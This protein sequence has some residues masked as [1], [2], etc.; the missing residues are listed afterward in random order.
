[1]RYKLD[2]GDFFL[3][4]QIWGLFLIASVWIAHK[5]DL[6]EPGAVTMYVSIP[7]ALVM[8]ALVYFRLNDLNWPRILLLPMPLFYAWVLAKE[9]ASTGYGPIPLPVVAILGIYSGLLWLVVCFPFKQE[10]AGGR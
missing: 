3:A 8:L 4:N 5:F 2:S 10:L 7:F 9:V 6:G 1:M